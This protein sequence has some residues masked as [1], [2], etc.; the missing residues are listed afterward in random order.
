[1]TFDH[2]DGFFR[3]AMDLEEPAGPF[4]YQRR[5]ASDYGP[6]DFPALLDVPTGL[7]KTAAVVLAWLWRRGRPRPCGFPPHSIAAG[8]KRILLNH[9]LHSDV[10]SVLLR[11]HRQRS[12]SEDKS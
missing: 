7:G 5:L 10:N 9:A 8:R 12:R 3:Q 2:Y 4:D 6:D 1:M 11:S